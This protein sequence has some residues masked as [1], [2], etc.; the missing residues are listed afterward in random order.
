[1]MP[2]RLPGPLVLAAG[3]ARVDLAPAAGGAIAGYTFRG[4][5]VLRPTPGDARAADNVRRHACYP[6]VPY[7]N[8]IADACLAVGGA[9]HALARNFGDHPHAI[10]GVGW[11][12][13]WTVASADAASAL[14]AL[15]HDPAGEGATAWPWPFRAT[16]AFTLASVDGGALL[17]VKLALANTGDAA[18]PFGLGWHPFLPLAADSELGFAADGVWLN[19]AT[20]IPRQHAAV[21]AA[22]RFDPPRA[23]GDAQLDNVFTDWRGC[24]TLRRP[25]HGLDVAL[26]A[27]R[28]CAF[29]VV[30]VP[31]G[32]DFVALEPVTHMTDAFNRAARGAC[33][34]GT[35]TLEP[36][37]AFS[38]TMQI[39]VRVSR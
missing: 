5:D 23:V 37:A 27:D 18:F 21:P 14:L 15:D 39:S 4:H 30:Y 28:A 8:R 33:G 34:T 26:A 13:P 3:E 19:D 16:Q 20:Q 12:R 36:G 32:R 25:A 6:L 2:R 29:L 31:P 1:M 10:H 9:T 35:R 7:S 11:Q 22:W 38:C 24:A 17:T